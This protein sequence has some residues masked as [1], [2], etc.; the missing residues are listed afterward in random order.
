MSKAFAVAK[1]FMIEMARDR[2]TWLS[3]IL[4][5]IGLTFIMGA[6]FGGS[7]TQ[8]KV[9]LALADLDKSTYS[10]QF[11][12]KFKEEKSFSIKSYEE[13][14][15]RDLVKT[16]K[17]TAAV[18]I[19]N[20]YGQTLRDGGKTKIEV[21]SVA[22]DTNGPALQEIIGG[23]ANRYNTDSAAASLT[24]KQLDNYGRLAPG[25]ADKTWG[26][27]FT[28]ADKKWDPP[29]VEVVAKELKA[30][31]VRGKKTLG[32]GFRQASLGFA[33]TF[34]LFLL[35][36]GGASILEERHKNTLY[37]LLSTPTG[38]YTILGGKITGIYLSGV[39]QATILIAAGVFLFGV[40]WGREPLPLIA[41]MA[42]YLLCGAAL[43]VFIA[44]IVRTN[45]QLQSIAPILII[46]MA[47]VGGCYWPVE[48][49]PP[50]MQTAAKLLPTGWVMQGLVDLIIRGHSW[51]AVLLPIAVLLGFTAVFLSLGAWRL[52]FE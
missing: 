33:V 8:P 23:L 42:V 4:L 34:L 3:L 50:F 51:D 13:A 35:V 31:G 5:P 52:K 49:T 36:E 11:V 40:N 12:D 9:K 20:A 24:V 2:S 15:A 32:F 19:P 16:S 30:S 1:V 43:G 7:T 47:M 44:S 46:S 10:E 39:I 28:E 41:L 38:K 25:S 18:I 37:R 6:A 14:P 21:I 22:G 26:E 48:I 27:V 45:A 17:V 29:P